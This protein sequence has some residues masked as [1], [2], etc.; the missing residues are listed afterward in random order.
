[1]SNIWGD[2]KT[3]HFYSLSIDSV[4]NAIESLGLKTTGRVIQLN[5]MENRVYEV[6]IDLDIQPENPSE[7]FKIIKF[8]RP[9]RWSKEQILEEHEFI[10]DLVEYELQA[11]APLKFEGQ[12]LFED[13]NG[14][15]FTLFDKKG[16][17]AADEWTTPLLEQM[18]RLLARMHN[19]GESKEA[20]QY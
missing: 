7:K 15:Y 6:E 20:K 10:H 13:E 2:D 18:G 8:Y 12:S 5:S 9:G 11:I 14:L 1:M 16:G 4:L 3:S 19:I 17:R